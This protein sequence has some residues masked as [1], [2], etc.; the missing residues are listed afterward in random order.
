MRIKAK[1]S[2]ILRACLDLLAAERILAF[3]MNVGTMKIDERFIKFGIPGMADIL[4]FVKHEK[5]PGTDVCAWTITPLWIET[6]SSRGRQ[7]MIQKSFEQM[8]RAADHSYIVAQSSDDLWE[9]IK[10]LRGGCV[11]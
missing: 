9:R 7:R 1:E 6:K 2:E 4:A 5:W 8:V 11:D 3:R 10:R